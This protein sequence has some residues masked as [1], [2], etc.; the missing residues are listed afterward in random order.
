MDINAMKLEIMQELLATE[1][2]QLLQKVQQLF[3]AEK[4][5]ELSQDQIQ[6]LEERRQRYLSGDEE[7]YTWEQVKEQARKELKG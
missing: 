6:M 1:S 5:F 7:N 2:K 4:N 3:H